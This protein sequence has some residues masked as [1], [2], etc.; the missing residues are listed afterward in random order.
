MGLTVAGSG[1]GE[2]TLSQKHLPPV[3]AAGRELA[4]GPRCR[5]DCLPRR[6]G[7]HPQE[8][9]PISQRV[10]DDVVTLQPVCA[11]YFSPHGTHCRAFCQYIKKT[12]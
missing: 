9:L 7:A 3:H 11:T 2:G 8:I 10:A 6:L 5:T 1:Y 4:C 12:A